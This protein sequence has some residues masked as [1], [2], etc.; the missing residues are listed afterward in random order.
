MKWTMKKASEKS[1]NARDVLASKTIVDDLL[2]QISG[3]AAAALQA[4]HPR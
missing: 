3:G 4:C 1:S 2:S